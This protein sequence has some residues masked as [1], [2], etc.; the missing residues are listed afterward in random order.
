MAPYYTAILPIV[1]SCCTEVSHNIPRK[2]LKRV[3]MF[4]IQRADGDCN[5]E[6]V[7]FH[8]KHRRF[9][10]SPNR[11]VRQWMR[12]NTVKKIIKDHI[13]YEK[14]HHNKRNGRKA[15]RKEN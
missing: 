2:L 11:H 3:N 10:V 8:T 9:C 14:K 5:L 13:C 7:I 6:A 1:S 15:H 12:K 4:C